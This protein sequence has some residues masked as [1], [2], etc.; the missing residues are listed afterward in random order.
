MSVDSIGLSVYNCTSE[1][2]GW[3]GTSVCSSLLATAVFALITWAVGIASGVRLIC[4]SKKKLNFFTFLHVAIF[5]YNTIMVM[6]LFYF[7]TFYWYYLD[8]F[9]KTTT[10][11][12]L[13]GY[14][15]LSVIRFK[16]TPLYITR[17][18]VIIVMV[19]L[20]LPMLVSFI[21]TMILYS[22][23][24][25]REP[26]RVAFHVFQ[27]LVAILFFIIAVVIAYRA[28]RS[29]VMSKGYLLKHTKPLM[30][31]ILF[32]MLNAIVLFCFFF[33]LFGLAADMPGDKCTA[34][35][36]KYYDASLT[37]FAIIGA[38]LYNIL[39]MW[40]LYWY[41]FSTTR[42]HKLDNIER[43]AET[44]NRIVTDDEPFGDD[45]MDFGGMNEAPPTSYAI[46]KYNSYF[47]AQSEDEMPILGVT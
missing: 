33:F 11:Y 4:I 28:E 16:I 18:L 25:C 23:T 19:V 24:P 2:H 5:V 37:Q 32:Y 36:T 3:S 35:M 1:L 9:I 17:K 46:G 47:I 6:Y 41:I 21:A 40:S 22:S 12:V 15:A 42:K 10:F 8:E 20:Y 43:Y 44:Q 34:V 38:F 27:V 14:F 39:P 7:D 29:V 13:T 26:S 45:L 31:I 30:I